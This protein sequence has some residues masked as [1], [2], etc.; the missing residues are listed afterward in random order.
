MH[1]GDLMDRSAAGCVCFGGREP[2]ISRM[3]ARAVFP[4]NYFFEWFYDMLS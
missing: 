1:Y 2:D 3:K 4:G